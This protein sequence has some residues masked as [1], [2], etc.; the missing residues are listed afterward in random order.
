MNIILLFYY[1]IFYFYLFDN[2]NI[3][4]LKNLYIF[5]NSNK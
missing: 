3:K 2:L 1:M 4:N 5:L